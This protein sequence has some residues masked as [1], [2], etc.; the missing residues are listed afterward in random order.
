MPLRDKQFT[1]DEIKQLEKKTWIEIKDMIFETE[2]YILDHLSW[3][4]K[5]YRLTKTGGLSNY[6]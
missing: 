2:P 5:R 6:D 4:C 1:K 3:H